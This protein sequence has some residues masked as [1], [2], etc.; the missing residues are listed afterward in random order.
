MYLGV[1]Q[2]AR[3]IERARDDL[4]SPRVVERDRVHD[5]SVP[6]EG[7]KRVPRRGIPYLPASDETN[8][9]RE[10]GVTFS[11]RQPPAYWPCA[12]CVCMCRREERLV[13][14]LH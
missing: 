1:P 7:Q 2:L 11:L 4:V 14:A 5:V 10:P 9:N 8:F 12:H 3:L 13:L 6:V